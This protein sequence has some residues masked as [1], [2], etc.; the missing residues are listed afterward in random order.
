MFQIMELKCQ[1][2]QYAWGKLG[3]KS[4]AAEFAASGRPDDFCVDGTAPY[5]ELW[6][7]T[8][9]NGPSML[10]GP[11][12]LSLE[13]HIA[14]DPQML[15][16]ES[17]KR[18][19]DQLPYLFKVLSVNKA[20]SIQAHPDKKHAEQ[21]HKER[22]DVYKD[23]N[24]KP[25]MAIALTD[26]EALCGFRPLSQIQANLKAVPSLSEAIGKNAAEALLKAT[27]DNHGAALKNAF[28][29]LMKC[30]KDKLTK[31]LTSLKEEIDKKSCTTGT[32][33]LNV[34]FQN[35]LN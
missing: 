16:A 15:G 31:L 1:V 23:D 2:Q 22:P 13:A 35:L 14:S 12:G 17:R 10:K 25:E 19:G 24:H 9:P 26:F 18:F 3:T 27:K 32:S 21:L 28:T 30:P 5:A 33:F 11:N 4:L 29:A 20:L 34:A 6:M 8:H 7:G